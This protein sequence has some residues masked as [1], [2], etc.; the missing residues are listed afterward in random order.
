MIPIPIPDKTVEIGE[1]QGWVR[2]VIAGPDGDLT[3]EVR[4]VEALIGM[5]MT[6]DG[7]TRPE[8]AVLIQIETQDMLPLAAGGMRFWLSFTGHIVPFSMQV[9]SDEDEGNPDDN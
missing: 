5:V 9:F 2:R 4:P 3:G 6:G 7:Q 1:K 8:L